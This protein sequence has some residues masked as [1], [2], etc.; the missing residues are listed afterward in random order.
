[1]DCQDQRTVDAFEKYAH[2]LQKCQEGLEKSHQLVLK[3]ERLR[4]EEEEAEIEEAYQTKW[5][6]YEKQLE[7]QR[8]TRSEVVDWG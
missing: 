4:K 8:K 3:L 7:A 1:L 6:W 2:A 5:G